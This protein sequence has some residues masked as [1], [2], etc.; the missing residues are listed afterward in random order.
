MSRILTGDRLIKSVRKRTMLPDDT[1]V[2]TDQDILDVA[3]EELDVNLLD[4]LLAIHAEHLVVSLDI[5]KNSSGVYEIP[6]RAIGNKLRD[7]SLVV[8]TQIYE[9]TQ[10][11]IGDLS[12]YDIH[13][14]LGSA[15]DKFYI[16]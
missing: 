7:V 5:E 8:G 13:D 16:E 12:D 14:D 4:K 1:S 6:S 11:G 3:N 9:L 2:F 15:L 10:V